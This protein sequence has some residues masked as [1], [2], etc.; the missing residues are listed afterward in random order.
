MTR[1]RQLDLELFGGFTGKQFDFG[2]RRD[3]G[4]PD[5]HVI[6]GP[7]EAGKTTTMEGYLR[8]LYGFP[9]REPYDFLHQRKN[10]RVSG[11]LDIDG[12]ETAFTRLPTRDPSLRDAHGQELPNSALQAHLGG[13][14]E[15]D[16]RNLLC[17]DDLTIEK[18]GEEI[19]RAKGDIGRLLFSAA[20]GIS[21]LSDVLDSV[22]S[23]ADGLY[24]KRASTTRLAG[25]KKEH[26]EVEK[27]IRELD[28]SASQYRGLK[29]A[30]DDALLEEAQVSERRKDLFAAKAQLDARIKS[31]PLLSEIDALDEKLADFAAWPVQLD[32]DPEDLV[33]MLAE[34]TTAQRDVTNHGDELEVLRSDLAAIEY[35]PEHLALTQ[36]LEDLDDLRSRYATADLDLD[37][38]HKALEQVLADMGRASQDLG[39]PA[40]IDPKDLVLSSAA[41]SELEQARERMRDAEAAVKREQDEVAA[42]DDKIDA[43][44]EHLGTLEAQSCITVDLAA[45]FERFDIDTLSARHAAA[46]ETLK[47]ARRNRRAALDALTTKGQSFDTLPTSPLTLE[48]AETL[49]DDLQNARKRHEVAAEDLENIRAEIAERSARIARIKA[50]DGLI[51]DDEARNIRTGRDDLWKAHRASLTDQT[52]N[53]FEVEMGRVDSAMDL[54]LS[55]AADIG[56]LRQHEQDLAAA[57][58][59]LK[60]V[61]QQVE[62]LDQARNTVL[63]R[64]AGAATEAGIGCLISPEFFVNWLRKLNLAVQADGELRRIQDEHQETFQKANRLVEVLSEHIRRDAPEF[65]ELVAVAKTNLTAQR[66]HQENL[67][68]AKARIDELTRDQTKRADKLSGIQEVAAAARGDWASRVTRAFPQGLDACLLEASLQPLR[69]L[70][71]SDKER[72]AL[73]RQVSAMEDD[74]IQFAEKVQALAQRVGVVTTASPLDNYDALADLAKHAVDADNKERE[75]NER[76]KAHEKSMAEA[77][78]VLEDIDLA[79]AELARV[80]PESVDTSSLGALRQAVSTASNVIADRAKRAELERSLTSHLELDRLENARAVLAEATQTGLLAELDEVSADLEGIEIRYK[81]TI[82]ARTSAEQELRAIGGDADVVLL[83]ERKTTLE[84]EMQEAALRHLELSL[85]HRLAETAIR[86]Y[87]D[88]HRSAMMRATETA[89]AELTNGAYS[90]LQTQID[91]ASE[92]LLALDASGMAKQAQDMSKGTRFQLYL[93]LRAAAYEQLADQGASLPFFC[94]DIFETFDEDRT[95]SACRVM[96]RVG[97]RGQAIYLTH[98]QHVVDIAREVC[99]EGVQIHSIAE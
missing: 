95:R 38:R 37:R 21:E 50:V 62:T 41:L 56:T 92:T 81:S 59:R 10:L 90:K 79:V 72:V 13:L 75:L 96:E 28:V 33:R 82:E 83:V 99:G 65:D 25:L 29:K 17:L 48:E 42:I 91:G 67:R 68:S 85:G 6:Y 31:L 47:T 34:Q 18:G 66:T 11:L 1:L 51:D 80:F 22:Q 74:Q 39:A 20:A 84:L 86:R 15:E 98:H 40:G 14:S 7:N 73:E 44:K 19:T 26:A 61:E 89:F 45:V 58:A 24:R 88:A 93:A 49:L 78:K 70:R 69:D 30:A 23:E 63:E 4:T 12:N 3:P 46:S 76:I 43:A 35:H 2:P 32:V 57:K 16:Y 9:H 77:Q 5:F 71:E 53:A 55:Q 52:A 54:R 8:L 60:T 27:Q 97:R 36:E 94:D 87:R 64:L